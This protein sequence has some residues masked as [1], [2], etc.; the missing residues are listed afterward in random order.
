MRQIPP[1]SL[2]EEKLRSFNR[3][4]QK[5]ANL[6][7]LLLACT[8]IPVKFTLTASGEV[9]YEANHFKERLDSMC[10]TYRAELSEFLARLPDGQWDSMKYTPEGEPL[11]KR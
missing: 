10:S 7:D 6:N 4:H 3:Q 2:L 8:L 9:T 11:K 1:L 5:T